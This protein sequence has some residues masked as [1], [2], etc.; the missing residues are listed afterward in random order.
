MTK[1]FKEITDFLNTD[2]FAL[3][4]DGRCK[5]DHAIGHRVVGKRKSALMYHFL[6]ENLSPYFGSNLDSETAKAFVVVMDN[7]TQ[8]FTKT[9]ESGFPKNAQ[10][11][12]YMY[13][14]CHNL[15]NGKYRNVPVSRK[16]IT[17]ESDC[18][19]FR[20][21]FWN[22]L[23]FRSN[24]EKSGDEAWRIWRR[25]TKTQHPLLLMA[26]NKYDKLS[27]MPNYCIDIVSM[28]PYLCLLNFIIYA[29]DKYGK[30]YSSY[31]IGDHVNQLSELKPINFFES[32]GYD[33]RPKSAKLSH[34]IT[35]DG[36]IHKFDSFTLVNNSNKKQAYE[37]E[38]AQSRTRARNLTRFSFARS[39]GS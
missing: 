27:T 22:Q 11:W 33:N 7:E 8:G 6:T 2:A 19:R 3:I 31:S 1:S 14:W 35:L 21:T 10:S 25:T 4:N 30:H 5:F 34:V 38:K 28:D 15:Y 20:G 39:I 32:I 23:T 36:M 17:P 12:E 29:S 13:D 16:L 37:Q 9:R 26:K 18:V 24:F